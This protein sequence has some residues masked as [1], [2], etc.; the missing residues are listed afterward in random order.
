MEEENKE[1]DN[2]YKEFKKNILKVDGPRKHKVTNSIGVYSAYKHIR[3][4]KWFDIGRPLTEHEFYTIIRQVNNYLANNLMCGQEVVFPHSLGRLELRKYETIIKMK[5]GK[6]YTNLPTDWSAT[7][8]LWYEDEEAYKN[9][10]LVKMEEKETFFRVNYSK[11][12]AYFNNRAFYAF[13]ANR[14]IKREIQNKV[15]NGELEAF[16]E[17]K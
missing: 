16:K 4:N 13:N 11:R 10:T 6:L 14:N 3:K 8:K 5:N 2:Q 15:K 1:I 17:F 7:I 9:K 12:Y